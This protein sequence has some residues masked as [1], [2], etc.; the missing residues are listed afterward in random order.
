M[1]TK[2]ES[3]LRRA[4]R[5]SELTIA[6]LVPVEGFD[7]S[8]E[9]YTPYQGVGARGIRN[10]SSKLTTAALPANTPFFRMKPDENTLEQLK[11]QQKGVK[12][13]TEKKLSKYER[14]LMSE[15][16]ASGDRSTIDE[17]M[18]HLLVAGN[19][20]LD[21][22]E[23]QS[24]LFKL[25]SYVC[26]RSPRGQVVEAVLQ[27]GITYSTAPASVKPLLANSKP[28][29]DTIIFVYTHILLI[30]GFYETYQEVL[31]KMIPGTKAKYKGDDMPY[32]F[33]RFSRIDGEDYGRGFV[34]EVYGDLSSLEALTEAIVQGAA[35]AAKVIFLVNPNGTTRVKALRDTRNL[36]FAEGNAAD[37][38]VLRMDKNADFAVAERMA[39]TIERRLTEQFMLNSSAT[40]D[41][42]RVTAEEVRFLASELDQSLSGIFSILAVEFQLPYIKRK[43]SILTKSGAVPKLPKDVVKPVIITGMQ[44][45]GRSQ[46]LE[47]LRGF[48]RELKESVG[49]QKAAEVIDVR[50]F[51]DRLAT[52]LQVDTDELIKDEDTILKE[53]Q[54]LQGQQMAAQ[55][56]PGAIQEMMKSGQAAQIASAG[57]A[58]AGIPQ[59]EAPQG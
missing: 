8:Q 13:D 6:S 37:V 52:A 30:N 47:R 7:G 59:G 35:A 25:D 49:E 44:A 24:R 39:S 9:L 38:T 36:G 22:T 33:L 58:Q 18:K 55:A 57:A 4:R 27:E 32:L 29:D 50:I 10:L 48:M 2:R 19:T 16:E 40:R 1:K 42:E 23:N 43:M 15:T 28:E 51:A 5:A 21:T 11:A 54:E 14:I 45:L 34:E 41:A 20:C 17:L 3:Y 26:R 46:D 31:G 56:A 53:R 12:T